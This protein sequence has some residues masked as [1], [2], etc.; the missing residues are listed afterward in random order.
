MS[1]QKKL[2][3]GKVVLITGSSSGIGRA[4]AL[5]FAGLGAK[6]VITARNDIKLDEV[7]QSAQ[8]ISESNDNIL[9]VKADLN[10]RQDIEILIN[11]TISTFGKLDVL[12]NNAGIVGITDIED[13][14]MEKTFNNI[15]NTNVG[16]IVRLCHLAVP[17]LKK[18]K[19][20]IVSVSSVASTKPHSLFFGY[21]MAKSCVDMLTKCLAI[22]LGNSGIR[23]N[24]V[25]PAVIR[26]N[27]FKAGFNFS[28]EETQ[29]NIYRDCE[30]TYPLQRPGEPEEVAETIA[31]L[32]SDKA[33]FISGTTLE[34]DGGSMWTS[35]GANPNNNS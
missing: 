19:G 17:H 25:N 10:V 12:V 14:D 35:R 5:T 13:K 22:D 32:A 28:E 1:C 34:V 30:Q 24:T 2:F 4:T 23:V 6:V 11:K 8:L 33:S 15:M 9:K 3:D 20:N 16:S 31:F 18:T 26:T 27:I 21:C 29:R 7:V